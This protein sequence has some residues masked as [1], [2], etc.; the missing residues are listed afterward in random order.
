MYSVEFSKSSKKFLRKITQ[1]DR[2]IIL[3]KVHSI[4]QDPFP[5]LKKLQGD[6]FWRLRVMKYRAI[7]DVI[8]SGKRLIVLRIGPRKNIY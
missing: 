5:Y 1:Q 8:I 4:K 2:E 7:V 6:K 3:K